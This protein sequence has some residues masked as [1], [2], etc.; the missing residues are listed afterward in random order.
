MA[1]ADYDMLNVVSEE[2]PIEQPMRNARQQQ[3]MQSLNR[4]MFM[5]AQVRTEHDAVRNLELRNQFKKGF[6]EIEKTK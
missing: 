1:Y 6:N 3:Q 4:N 2:A 5:N